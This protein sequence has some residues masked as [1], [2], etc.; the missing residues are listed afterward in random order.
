MLLKLNNI[1][2]ISIYNHYLSTHKENKAAVNNDF[3]HNSEYNAL[4]LLN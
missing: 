2:K 1:Y 4:Y 3:N